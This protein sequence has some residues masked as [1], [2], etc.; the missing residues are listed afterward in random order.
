[1][2]GGRRSG[3][4]LGAHQAPWLDVAEADR[5][6]LKKVDSCIREGRRSGG[7]LGSGLSN[8]RGGGRGEALVRDVPAANAP[9]VSGATA[10][11]GG[12]SIRGLER[13]SADGGS[14]QES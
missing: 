14:Q 9:V 4:V 11:V 6:S 5:L 13:I 10:D 7:M 1:M 8:V 12:A 2:A 3:G